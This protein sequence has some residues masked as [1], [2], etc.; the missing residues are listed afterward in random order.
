MSSLQSLVQTI[1]ACDV[2]AHSTPPLPVTPNPILRASEHAKI[3]IISQAPGTLAHA[4][5]LPFNDPSGRR[6]RDWLGVNPATFYDTD[7]FAITPMGF[8]FP[9]QDAKGGDL[10]PRPECAPLW[11]ARLDAKLQNVELI[12]L[13]GLYA[14]KHY[15]GPTAERTLTETV[16]NW[17]HYGPRIMPLPHPSWRNNAWIKTHDWFADE[18][19]ELRRRVDDLVTRHD[20]DIGI[21]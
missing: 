2:C 10:P 13:V 15:L 19:A 11:Q 16:R 20:A 17:R 14:V 1:R 8:C 7:N 5:S 4:S 21:R 3:R 18:L 12:L 9:G 6:L